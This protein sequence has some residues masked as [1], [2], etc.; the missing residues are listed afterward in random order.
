MNINILNYENE[1]VVSSLQ[2]A[3]NL[4][5]QH[6]SLQRLITKYIS[7]LE[8]FGVVR[9]EI[10]AKNKKTFY[11]NENQA[12]FLGTLSKNT[13]L[14]VEFKNALVTAFSNLKETKQEPTKELTTIE[15]LEL[16]TNEIKRLK[17]Q[18]ETTTKTLEYKQSI[19]VDMA[20][21]VPAKTMRAVINQSVRNYHEKTH[22]AYSYIWNNLYT[23]FK[24]VYHIDLEARVKGTKTSK[25][26]M[27]EKIG[28]LEDLYL[29]TLKMYETEKQLI[30]IS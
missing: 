5:L 4:D 9:F 6:E 8:L 3:E 23:E 18:L 15:I 14:V 17:S 20:E 28:V 27:A 13:E 22:L 25:I 30:K 24:Y 19:I 16:T 7:K 12:L 29:L 26:A 11:L 10:G 2:I 1:K 21:K